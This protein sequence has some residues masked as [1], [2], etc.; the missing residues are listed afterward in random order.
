[1]YSKRI[2]V[3]VNFGAPSDAALKYAIKLASAVNGRITCLHVNEE[4]DFITG[5]F[6]TKE[7]SDRRRRLAEDTLSAKANEILNDHNAIPYEI[8]VTKGNVHRKVRE[9][10]KDLNASFIIMA[11]S[12]SADMDNCE[13]GSNTLR[14]ITKAEIPVLTVNSTK[15]LGYNSILLPLDLSKPVVVKLQT[16]LE[17]AKMFSFEVNVF[18]VMKSEWISIKPKYQ[19]RLQEI[20]QLFVS[21]G[22]LCDTQLKVSENSFSEEILLQARNMNAG[23]ILMMTQQEARN[24]DFFLGSTVHQIINESE[25]PVLSIIPSVRTN[26]TSNT[27]A[28]GNILNPITLLQMH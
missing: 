14:V 7:I 18:T 24:T 20:Q 6:L 10:A 22:V 12:D 19:K 11:K 3:P 5:Q 15:H 2:L 16:T 8:I 27:S 13:L 25:F 4:P 28:W 17:L 26:E 21:E 9:K 1:M 23:M